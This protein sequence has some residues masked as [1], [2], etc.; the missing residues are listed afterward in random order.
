MKMKILNYERKL[1]RL[2]NF[3][4]FLPDIAFDMKRKKILETLSLKQL[5][6]EII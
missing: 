2:F 4:L 1:C 5:L 6:L 3:P